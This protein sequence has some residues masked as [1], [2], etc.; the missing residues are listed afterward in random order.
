MNFY[1]T[2]NCSLLKQ[3]SPL[4][5]RRVKGIITGYSGLRSLEMVASCLMKEIGAN[6]VNTPRNE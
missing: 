5:R 6:V 2:E 3:V 1:V 4:G